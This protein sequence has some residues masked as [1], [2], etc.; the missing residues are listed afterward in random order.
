MSTHIDKI[1]DFLI[2][3]KIK[4]PVRIQELP[5]SG[6]SRIYFRLIY[7]DEDNLL[8]A[9]NP[10]ISENIAQMA[11][12]QHFLSLGLNVPEIIARNDSYHYLLQRDLGDKNL[13]SELPNMDDEQIAEAYKKVI[14]N[15][16][17][18]QIDGIKGLDLDVAWPVKEFNRRSIMWDLNYFKYYF[19]KPNEIL[20]D[21][22]KLE[23]EFENFA[24]SLLA[25]DASYFMYRDFQARNIMLKDDEPW[26]IDFQSGRKGPLHY[27]LASLLFQVKANLGME[28]R[29]L[30]L[31]YYISQLP[32]SLS[33]DKINFKNEF[34]KFVWFRLMQVMGAYGFRGL[35]QKKGH[36]LQSIPY[37][38]E[39]ISQMEIVFL[40]NEEFPLI[41]KILNDIS[42]LKQFKS[43][44][45]DNE[46]LNVIISSF[47]YK[48]TSYP[49]DTSG[50]GGGFVFDCRFLP[51]PGRYKELENFNGKQKEIIEFLETK[52]PM[53]EFI[54]NCYST[55]KPA[56][57]RYLERN[58][59]Q[60]QIN[61]GCTGGRHRSVYSAEKIATM[62]EKQF[63]EKINIEVVH[64]QLNRGV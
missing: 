47:S 37:V 3:K 22:Q 4:L 36:F 57:D 61:F 39:L 55:I 17:K 41:A 31:D 49:V 38:L 64:H 24:S 48:K 54:N 34:Y 42:H 12:T 10:E 7:P 35:V 32:D 8:V 53:S 25:V 16:I 28:K 56:V 9:F 2:S 11:F 23:D 45:L 5:S 33:I 62:L 58:F 6:S 19:V 27:D 44:A 20:F 40:L 46:I 30:L 13:L 43:K 1:K 60:L 18:F 51:N 26:F 14:N 52:P 59:N 50:N 15:L 63:G 21:E 29:E